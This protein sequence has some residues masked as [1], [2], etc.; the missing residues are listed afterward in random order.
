[1]HHEPKRWNNFCTSVHYFWPMSLLPWHATHVAFISPS[2]APGLYVHLPTGHLCLY[3]P[4]L[5]KSWYLQNRIFYLPP[6]NF[7][8]LLPSPTFLVPTPSTKSFKL[9]TSSLLTP[10]SNQLHCQVHSL[11]FSSHPLLTI[12]TDYNL[13][14][15]YL[16][17]LFFFFSF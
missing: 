11:S 10:K 13:D 7:S 14:Y 2:W 1:M 3:D 4:W 12:S 5:F 16:P 6:P 9:A 17:L 8:M 15:Q